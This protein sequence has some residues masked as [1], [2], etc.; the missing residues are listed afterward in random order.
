MKA[1]IEPMSFLLVVMIGI[2][3]LIA[4]LL[5]FYGILDAA[6]NQL[7]FASTQR[8]A[9]AIKEACITGNEVPIEFS[10]Q[11][12][13]PL[14]KNFGPI[15]L[16]LFSQKKIREF[17]DPDFVL[18]YEMFPPGEGIA[19]EVHHE[20]ETRGVVAIPDNYE[21]KGSEDLK[22]YID[23]AKTEIVSR[24]PEIE[25][26]DVPVVLS[27]I[28]L[29]PDIDT[30]TGEVIL[31]KES[32][33][34]FGFGEWVT[35]GISGSDSIFRFRNYQN[36]ERM[37]KTFVKYMSCGEN[38]LCLKTPE[39]VFA[40]PLNECQGIQTIQYKFDRGGLA[41]IKDMALGFA[42]DTAE[43]AELGIEYAAIRS[44]GSPLRFLTNLRSLSV[45]AKG[46]VLGNPLITGVVVGEELLRN[47]VEEAYLY[48]TGDLSFASPCY[49]TGIVK[50]TECTDVFRK[51]TIYTYN[52]AE[53]KL[54]ATG[55]H[56][57]S[58]SA[59]RKPEEAS[60]KI[61]CIEIVMGEKKDHCFTYNLDRGTAQATTLLTAE[62]ILDAPEFL[63]D[64]TV[65]QIPVIG[66]IFGGI[67]NGFLYDNYIVEPVRKSTEHFENIFILTPT[68][69]LS[70]LEETFNGFADKITPY[71]P[72]DA[73]WW[74]YAGSHSA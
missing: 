2:M 27:N 17:G 54:D 49:M 35:P 64:N 74:P 40:F 57:T 11:Q 44:G 14:L 52:S 68:E 42:E 32:Q 39:G 67:A 31:E 9:S 46:A 45:G 71:D 47:Y 58:L 28:V 59:M 25:N 3:F 15:P 53:D 38:S 13:K 60:E 34:F 26:Q 23:N 73:W 37:D 65:G 7:A 36:L 56:Y 43:F 4:G 21:G 66:D 69:P 33:G 55:T 72:A 22:D 8:L 29:T 19:W 6:P 61:S 62:T 63:V 70:V 1:A 5:L 51:D 30:K 50:K 10:M 18:Y 12:G 24:H 41:E 20:F 16:R 48:R